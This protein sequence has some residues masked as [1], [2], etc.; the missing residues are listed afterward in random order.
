MR[1]IAGEY[2]RRNL[3]SPND[4][5]PA[6]PMPSMVRE[7]LFNLLRG[8][9]ENEAVLDAFAGSGAVG[10]EA[11]SRGASRCVFVENDKG[12]RKLL[13]KN[14]EH[15]GVGDRAE[16]VFGDA[17]GPATLYA[18]PDPCHLIFFDPP[19]PMVRDPKTWPRVR[20]AFARLVQR[21]DETGYAVL[22]TPYPFVHSEAGEHRIGED[23]PAPG[24]DPTALEDPF[25]D[26][27]ADTEVVVLEPGGPKV[28]YVDVDLRM[29]A[30]LGPE[31]H[32]YRGTAIHLYMRDPE[33]SPEDLDELRSLV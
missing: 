18:C 3:F 23:E 33:P 11:L 14:I 24:E 26:D 31:T 16:V 10:L 9:T 30:S 2:R 21:L 4:K 15:L 17:L 28:R 25:A 8:H 29:P 1:I 13:E 27:A 7:A 12:T 22:R 6:R 32:A 20:R 5:S 19:Y